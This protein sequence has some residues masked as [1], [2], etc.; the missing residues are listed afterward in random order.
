MAR[1][2]DLRAALRAVGFG[3]FI[4]RLWDAMSRDG[5]TTQ[6]AAVAYAWL[7]AIFPFLIFILTLFAYIPEKAKVNARSLVSES[8]HRVMAHDAAQTMITNLD[9]LLDQT[10]TGLLSFG[11]VVT[12]WIA[13]GGISMTM[14]ALDAAYGAPQSPPFYIQRPIAILLTIVVTVLVLIVFLLLPAGDAIEHLFKL[15]EFLPR[16]ILWIFTLTRYCV[17]ILLM[18]ATLSML[19]TY[20][21]TVRHRFAFFSPGSIFTV[22]VWIVLGEGF[23]FYVDKFGQF[24]KTYGAIGGVV[25]ILLFFYLDALVMLIGAEINGL[26]EQI[27]KEHQGVGESRS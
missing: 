27:Q 25:I 22:L 5:L 26:A 2:Q 6:A 17:A 18:L 23:R 8:L 7:F 1:L 15:R 12:L 10:H 3:S 24:Q 4:M 13:S 21:T 19:Y 11:L 16:H 9:Q 20:G 14:S